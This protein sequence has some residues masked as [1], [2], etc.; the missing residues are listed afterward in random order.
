MARIERRRPTPFFSRS[1]FAWG[2]VLAASCSLGWGWGAGQASAGDSDY[3]VGSTDAE[4]VAALDAA[5]REAWRDAKI[6]PSPAADDGPWLRRLFLDVIG[7]IPT[8]DETNAFLAEHSSRR[9]EAAIE[10]LTSSEY[11]AEFA[12]HWATVW[13]NLLVGRTVDND[14][15]VDRSALWQYLFESFS[16][17]QPLDELVVELVTAVGSNQA[18]SENFSPAVNYLSGKLGEDAVPATDSVS[19]L[20]L[21]MQVQCT[22][23]H[24]HPFN[25]YRQEQFWQMNAFFRQ[26]RVLRRYAGGDAAGVLLVDEDFIDEEGDAD[27]AAVFY[28]ERNELGRAVWPV[29]VNELV[30]A[31]ERR[32]LASGRLSV[33]N[34]REELADYIVHSEL[35][36]KAIVNRA[37]GAL[38]G[39]GFTKP[40][41]DMG[42]HNA[43][44]LPAALDRLSSEFVA[45]GFNFKRLIGWIAATQAYG[46]QSEAGRRNEKDDPA[47]GERPLYSRFY[48][49]QLTPE[50]LYNAI[51]VA[52]GLP[53][54]EA[55]P[56]D[57]QEARH[58]WVSQ[59]TRNL[60]T[61]D[62]AEATS[63]DGT[64]PQS[65]LLMNGPLTGE[66][67]S[68]E[69]GSF[70]YDVAWSNRSPTEKVNALFLSALGRRASREEIE[71]AGQLVGGANGDAAAGLQDL[72]WAIL[73]SNE[74]MLNH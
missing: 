62:G 19:R 59:F 12:E 49:R 41:D 21:G 64:I 7:R 4:V 39:V 56:A 71:V 58:E 10:R 40:V 38:L 25:K 18:G 8:L 36:P 5:V 45:S 65:L 54:R 73:N 55:E 68:I 70:L 31:P 46:L 52:G 3:P 27:H 20:F 24:R 26:A 61:D 67:V 11:E 28:S 33:V 6:T 32:P 35:F 1:N 63:F 30:D 43:P 15:I 14:N 13:T 9:R 34:R 44:H 48:A 50:T 60:G 66:A 53:I 42:P 17:N 37:W 23:C 16:A 74:F 47:L 69:E 22:Q 57:R 72:Y 2:A 29:F 51:C